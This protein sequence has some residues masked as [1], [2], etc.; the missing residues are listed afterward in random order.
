MCRGGYGSLTPLLLGLMNSSHPRLPALLATLADPAK[1]WSSVGL[2]SLSPQ[3]GGYGVGVHLN[4]LAV[5]RLG[6]IGRERRGIASN[7]ALRLAEA[8]RVRV[9]GAVFGSWVETGMVW[10]GYGDVDGE[11]R[12]ERGWT[13]WTAVV[14]LLMGLDFERGSGDESAGAGLGLG[15]PDIGFEDAMSVVKSPEQMVSSKTVVAWVLVTLLLF[16]L[17]RR[18]LRVTGRVTGAWLTR[19]RRA[20]R[21]GDAGQGGGFTDAIALDDLTK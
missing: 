1:L 18:V 9:V 5:L 19:E 16:L 12:G 10:E 21:G 15:H 20:S 2:R 6:E 17:R 13:G 11:G 4:V 3:D 8:L 14:L 7:W